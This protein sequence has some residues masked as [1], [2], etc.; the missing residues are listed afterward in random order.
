M[1]TPSSPLS[2]GQIGLRKIA[3]S[4]LV[5]KKK[6]SLI[7]VVTKKTEKEKKD[8]EKEAEKKKDDVAPLLAP[9]AGK[10]DKEQSGTKK[11]IGIGRKGIEPQPVGNHHDEAKSN[12]KANMIPSKENDKSNEKE[13]RRERPQ[14]RAQA[15]A[16]ERSLKEAIRKEENPALSQSRVLKVN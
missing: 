13:L 5:S 8:I 11:A 6:R 9:S 1:L 2:S 4:P 15:S 14:K 7:P 16:R 3:T 12:E 10:R